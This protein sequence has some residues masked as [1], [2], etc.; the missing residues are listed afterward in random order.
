M[1][2]KAKGTELVLIDPVHHKTAALCERFIQPR[3]G[4]DFA[5]AM[6][7]ARILFE[8]NWIDRHA[9]DYCDHVDEFRCLAMNQSVQDWCRQADVPEES[10]RDLARRLGTEKPTAILV[11]WGM[12]RRING[13]GMVRALDALCAISG[14]IGIPGGGVSFYFKRRGAFDT[15]FIG[16]RAAP[17]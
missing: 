8:N 11:G 2:A 10:A 6:A 12:G 7:V 4:S 14:N 13:A 3:P 16:L 1:D 15:S 9:G 17:R 5:L